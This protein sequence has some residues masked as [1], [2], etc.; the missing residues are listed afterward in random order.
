M[1]CIGPTKKIKGNLQRCLQERRAATKAKGKERWGTSTASDGNKGNLLQLHHRRRPGCSVRPD[2]S[3]LHQ[4]MCHQANH[5]LHLRICQ[6]ILWGMQNRFGVEGGGGI[7]NGAL[8]SQKM[9][10]KSWSSVRGWGKG[11]WAVRCKVRRHLRCRFF[12][13]QNPSGR[14]PFSPFSWPPTPLSPHLSAPSPSP[15]QLPSTASSSL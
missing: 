11:L 2:G 4:G 9:L 5:R 8:I 15:L 14:P 1:R 13:P 10:T 12:L 3:T 7:A 6:V